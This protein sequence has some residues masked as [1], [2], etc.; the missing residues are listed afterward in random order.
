[1]EDESH[2]IWGDASD[3]VWGRRNQKI[4]IPMVNFRERQT[5]FGALN[6]KSQI[7]H[8]EAYPRGAGNSTVDFVKKLQEIYA[9]SKKYCF[10]IRSIIR[11]S[12]GNCKKLV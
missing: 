1:M 11:L 4:A 12:L 2:L 6:L 7:F 10:I 8:V 9:G 5:Y 3:Y